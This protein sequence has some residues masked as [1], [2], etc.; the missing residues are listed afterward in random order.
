MEVS[1]SI[2]SLKPNE[3]VTASEEGTGID[4]GVLHPALKMV[5]DAFPNRI[6][7]LHQRLMEE[8]ANL[9]SQHEMKATIS[10]VFCLLQRRC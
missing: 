7:C 9:P 3:S 4:A 5:F 8:G 1:P 6:I 10:N 2:T